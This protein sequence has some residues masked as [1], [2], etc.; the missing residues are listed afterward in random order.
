EAPWSLRMPSFHSPT[1][2]WSR[3]RRGRPPRSSPAGRCAVRRGSKPPTITASPR[4]SRGRDIFRTYSSPRRVN[5]LAFRR[6]TR[7]LDHAACRGCN[8]VELALRI[9]HTALL[10]DLV[11]AVLDDDGAE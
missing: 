9:L 1:G 10:Q 3:S 2:F 8:D 6:S 4:G 5:C 7:R 11:S